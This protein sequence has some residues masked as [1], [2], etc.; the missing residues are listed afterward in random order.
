MSMFISPM[1]ADCRE[2][3][4][5]DQAYV[6]EP[7]IDGQRI[8][9]SRRGKETR[10][11]TADGLECTKQYPE[12]HRIPLEGDVVLD[13]GLYC[14]DPDSGMADAGLAMERMQLKQKK[15]IQ[16]FSLQ[17]PAQYM[18]W[19]ILFHKGRDL[20]PMPL[21]KRRA[22]LESLLQQNERFQL[23]PQTEAY[24]EELFQ[25]IVASS[26]Q[27]MMAK[28]K[29][30]PYVSRVSHDW[31]RIPNYQYVD[32]VIS[33][34]RKEPF[35]LFACIEEDGA[36]QS[37]GLI[38]SGVNEKQMQLFHSMAGKLAVKEDEHTVH[39]APEIRAR[40][41]CRGRTRHGMLRSPELIEFIEKSPK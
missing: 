10:L 5:S 7:K 31:I 24:G 11:F 41:Q 21:V 16:A 1:L 13:G 12:L 3:P 28:H 33:G 17:R 18:I 37:V 4:F 38:E 19:D 15:R 22:L 29:N 26:M 6:F 32:V 30:S 20:R 23:V 9:L 36:K 40:V 2:T 14:I 8:M 34:Y 25:S 27:G 39:L 35:G